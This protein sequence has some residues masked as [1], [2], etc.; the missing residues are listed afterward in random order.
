MR[1]MDQRDS[2]AGYVELDADQ[3]S[4]LQL[5]GRYEHYSDFDDTV[6]GKA[7]GPI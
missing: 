5:A 1:P 3:L 2:F 6:N 4:T 7:A